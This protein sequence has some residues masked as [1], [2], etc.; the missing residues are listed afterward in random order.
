MEAPPA[1]VVPPANF[2]VKLPK[3]KTD[4]PTNIHFIDYTQSIILYGSSTSSLHHL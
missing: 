4:Y 1:Q 2:S 3:P